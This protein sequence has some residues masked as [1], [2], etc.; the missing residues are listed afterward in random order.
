MT[1]K[2]KAL[3]AAALICVIGAAA[4]FSGYAAELINLPSGEEYTAPAVDPAVPAVDP[5]T[6]GYTEPTQP[7]V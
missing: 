7:V 5:V 2:L 4:C 6:P 3:C 1:K